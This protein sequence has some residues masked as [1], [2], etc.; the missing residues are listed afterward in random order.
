MELEKIRKID[1]DVATYIEEELERQ[2]KVK[3]RIV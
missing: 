1:S 3:F 2:R